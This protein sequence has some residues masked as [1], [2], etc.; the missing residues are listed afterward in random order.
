MRR[1]RPEMWRASLHANGT[2][3]KQIYCDG[4]GAA[5]EAKPLTFPYYFDG[6]WNAA[7]IHDVTL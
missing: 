6:G 2:A 7:S 5:A 4:P 3:R 1:F